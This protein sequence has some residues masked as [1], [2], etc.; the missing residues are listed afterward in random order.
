MH[1]LIQITTISGELIETII[2]DRI[3]REDVIV[4][5]PCGICA[6]LVKAPRKF[7]C[8]AHRQAYWE[9]RIGNS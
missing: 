1:V 5:S 3:P 6:E 2:V 8:D 9:K 7:C 4:Y